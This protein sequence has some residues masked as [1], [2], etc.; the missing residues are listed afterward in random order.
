MISDIISI[1]AM[2]SIFKETNCKLSTRS[3]QLYQNIL[4]HYFDD[5]EEIIGNLSSF[6]V[7]F[8]YIPN[9]KKYELQLHELTRANLIEIKKDTILFY[10]VW[11]KHIQLIRL[12]ERIKLQLASAYKEEMYNSQ[13][14]VEAVAMKLRIKKENVQQL[15]EMFFVEQDGIG[16]EY[17]N[18]SECR[19]HFI[20]WSQ[21]N[22]DKI[23]KTSV[24][25]NS[26]ILGLPN[27]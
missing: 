7:P 17:V 11:T 4:Q 22:A 13:Q 15:L 19:K 24:K 8:D 10:D 9:H 21:N 12:T 2:S 27:G 6:E 26:R 25:S 5:K 14:L 1:K 23:E 20:Y 18:E 16:K 3:M